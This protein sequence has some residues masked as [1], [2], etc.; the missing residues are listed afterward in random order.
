MNENYQQ[1]LVVQPQNEIFMSSIYTT[2]SEFFRWPNG[3][4]DTKLV[5]KTPQF[6]KWIARKNCPS[7]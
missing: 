3:L 6:Q 1:A 4:P 2:L 5:L 7:F